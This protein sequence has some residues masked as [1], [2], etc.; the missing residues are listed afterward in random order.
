ME[1]L[2]IPSE[3]PNDSPSVYRSAY[4]YQS[5]HT[6]TPVTP[7]IPKVAAEGANKFDNLDKHVRQLDSEL[8][9]LANNVRPLGSSVSLIRS[10]YALRRSLH[11]VRHLFRVN[12][13]SI[14]PTIFEN[15]QPASL[16]PII[17]GKRSRAMR[18][19]L[20]LVK[21]PNRMIEDDTVLTSDLEEFP[22]QFGRLGED[23]LS[24]LR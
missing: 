18:D 7:N 14:Y 13:S 24:F 2:K 9:S 12:A 17:L 4:D 16:E 22:E 5:S 11:Q 10:S 15:E 20:N 23:I 19:P 8:L 6:P 21:V 1:P 3:K